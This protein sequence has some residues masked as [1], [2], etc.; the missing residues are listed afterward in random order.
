M[1]GIE[2]GFTHLLKGKDQRCFL[3]CGSVSV[4][5]CT[6]LAR[7]PWRFLRESR[8]GRSQPFHRRWLYVNE[9]VPYIRIPTHASMGSSLKFGIAFI[10]SPCQSPSLSALVEDGWFTIGVGVGD[11]SGTRSLVTT[12]VELGNQLPTSWRHVS[13]ASDLHSSRD[14]RSRT[15]MLAHDD[16]DVPLLVPVREET[17]THDDV[18]GQSTTRRCSRQARL[19]FTGTE[20]LNLTFA[21]FEHRNLDYVLSSEEYHRKV[22]GNGAGPL[23]KLS[24]LLH[25]STKQFFLLVLGTLILIIYLSS[26]AYSL[27]AP[28]CRSMHDPVT[29]SVA[30]TFTLG[31]LTLRFLGKPGCS[32]IAIVGFIHGAVTLFIVLVFL[33][34]FRKYKQEAFQAQHNMMIVISKYLLFGSRHGR[35]G[36][37]MACSTLVFRLANINEHLVGPLKVYFMMINPAV[38]DRNYSACDTDGIPMGCSC[39]KL[40][41][42]AD[43]VIFPIVPTEFSHVI[44]RDSPLYGMNLHEMRAAGLEFLVLVYAQGRNH[45]QCPVAHA[46]FFSEDVVH[47]KHFHDMGSP[48]IN[49][50]RIPLD[51]MN[52]NRVES[53]GK[54]NISVNSASN[55]QNAWCGS[56]SLAPRSMQSVYL[57]QDAERWKRDLAVLCKQVLED[58]GASDSLQSAAEHLSICLAGQEG[59][60]LPSLL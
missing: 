52:F 34:S 32:G 55:T 1:A 45:K 59:V 46:T 48:G 21:R 60:D 39:L 25:K 40:K 7:M 19:Q 3:R 22:R 2:R 56:H 8:D 44:D 27:E 20:D 54:I 18:E 57:S 30:N 35:L 24:L 50:E 33:L 38:Y 37:N 51:F 17:T 4:V 6:S 12:A 53:N 29:F 43:N 47:G 36:G 49:S 42:A 11:H 28:S 16:G 5:R 58:K 41:E 31:A 14:R 13:P 9:L 26:S 15:R 23:S 10:G